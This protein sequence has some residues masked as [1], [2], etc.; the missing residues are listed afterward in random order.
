MQ[1][2]VSRYDAETASGA[3]LTDTGIELPFDAEALT[4]TPVR[5]LRLGQR[6]RLVTT[7]SGASLTIS[8]VHFITL[9]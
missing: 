4:R 2:T 8:E 5:L 1:A 3:V 6:V 9:P 7:G